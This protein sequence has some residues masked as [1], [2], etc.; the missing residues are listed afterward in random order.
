MG[1]TNKRVSYGASS[2]FSFWQEGTVP[3]EAK[4]YLFFDG[5]ELEPGEQCEQ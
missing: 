1:G 2:D 5:I 3:T 4:K